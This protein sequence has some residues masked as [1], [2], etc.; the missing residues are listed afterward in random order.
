MEGIDFFHTT[1]QLQDTVGFSNGF[2]GVF[3]G[4][5][6]ANLICFA[7]ARTTQPAYIGTLFTTGIYNRMLMQNIQGDFKINSLA[8][9][10]LTLS[11]IIGVSALVM[12][13]GYFKFSLQS[14]IIP[15][16]VTGYIVLKLGTI[17]LLAYVTQTQNGLNEHFLNHLIFFQISALTITPILIFTHFLPDEIQGLV[18]IVTISILGFITF[19]RDIQ[20]LIRAVRANISIFYIIL[21]LCTLELLP[22]V[23]ILHALVNNNTVIN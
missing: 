4:M 23:V 19:V 17:K 14:L 18:L 9:T 6:L 12:L 16:L 20:S 2:N 15:L 1:N 21:Y 3:W 22:F 13:A 5:M 11:Y 8:S 7:I 10:V